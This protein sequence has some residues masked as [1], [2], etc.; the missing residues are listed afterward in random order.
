M[1]KEEKVAQ[2]S[3]V[4]GSYL[5]LLVTL[6]PYDLRHTAANT[7]LQDN[8]MLCVALNL[9][10]KWLNKGVRWGRFYGIE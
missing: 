3:K 8:L 6:F 10:H 1:E 5:Q 7:A 2:V 4:N 9:L